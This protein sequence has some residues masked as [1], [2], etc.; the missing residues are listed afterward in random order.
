MQI[1]FYLVVGIIKKFDVFISRGDVMKFIIISS[2]VFGLLYA[3]PMSTFS[4]DDYQNDSITVYVQGEVV[5][6]KK[7]VLDKYSTIEDA[8]GFIELTDE[9]DVS[10][11]NLLMCLKDQDVLSIPKKTTVS[12]ISINTATVDELMTIPGIGKVKAEKIISYR[13]IN[14]LFQ[15]IED[16]MKIDGIKEKSFE[17]LK[18]FICL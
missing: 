1:F 18:D 8:L 9:A 6:E 11:F 5:E 13:E 10:G 15:T 17:K 2:L 14:G 16:I 4:L 3:W 12:K 7:L